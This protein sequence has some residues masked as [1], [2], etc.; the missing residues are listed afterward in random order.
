MTPGTTKGGGWSTANKLK[1]LAPAPPNNFIAG[2]PNAALLF[3][4]KLVILDV[5]CCYLWLFSLYINI[6]CYTT[7]LPPVWE[8]A[9]HLAVAGDV[10]DGVFLCC[11][12]SHEMYLM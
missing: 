9:V 12:F 2:R 10:Y 3:M 8:I 1:T 4:F 5:A 6:Q 7:R 11:L